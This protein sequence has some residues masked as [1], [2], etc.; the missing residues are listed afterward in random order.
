M[1]PH[2]HTLVLLW[3]GTLRIVHMKVAVKQLFVDGIEEDVLTDFH[4][5]VQI[6][7]D[8]DHPQLVRLLG[9][10]QKMPKLLL[11]TEL[12]IKGSLWDYYHNEK[13]PK[14]FDRVVM[15]MAL[16]MA[17]GMCYLHERRVLHRDLKSQNIWL[18]GDLGCKIGDF[19]MSRMNSQVGGSVGR[20]VARSVALSVAL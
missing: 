17:Q 5:E 7:R 13:P 14:N 8:M 16:Q 9:V 20:S 12:M 19:G 6:M 18:D 2:T 3:F 10:M 15:T 11:V 1:I 4:K